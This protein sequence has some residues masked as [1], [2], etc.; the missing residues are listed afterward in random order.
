MPAGWLDRLGRR[1]RG[2]TPKPGA[3][4]AGRTDVTRPDE[5]GPAAGDPDVA[6]PY[7]GQ[8]DRR[9]PDAGHTDTVETHLGLEH[10]RLEG[11]RQEAGRQDGGR[12][13]D[14]RQEGG[15]REGAHQD[16]G[17]LGLGRVLWDG[18]V[19]GTGFVVRWVRAA[20]FEWLVGNRFALVGLVV[21]AL[22]ALYGVARLSTPPHAAAAHTLVPR[23]AAVVSSLAVCP[24]PELGSAAKTRFGLVSP[25]GAEG[26][27]NA[28]VRDTFG[29]R[30]AALNHA[31]GGWFGDV[32]HP[33]GPL[34]VTGSGAPAAGLTGGQI[35][36]G[37]GDKNEL[38][39][40]HCTRPA[41][42][43]WFVGPG[44]EDGDVRLRL[45]NPDNGPATVSV[46]VYSDAG[47]LDGSDASAIFVPPHGKADVSLAKRAA[48]AQLAALHVRTSM[49]RVAAAVQATGKS[50][51]GAD[52]VPAG[53]APA[54]KLVVPGV[55]KGSGDRELLVAAP[56]DHDATV[57]VAAATSDGTIVPGGEGV[58]QVPAGSVM[59]MPLDGMLSGRACALTLTS[60]VP[61]VAGLRAR[62]AISGGADVAYTAAEPPLDGRGVAA[63]NR[64]DH[65]YDA[66]VTLTALGGPVTVR[67]TPAGPAAPGRPKDVRVAAG[68]TTVVTPDA[69][70]G[71]SPAY[72]IVVTRRSG[73]GRLYAARTL[74]RKVDGGDLMTVDP[75]SPAPSTVPVLPATGTL[76]A[77]AP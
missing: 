28:S 60:D 20:P 59:P 41:T 67:V 27:G 58:L 47:H 29:K 1:A 26:R 18:G 54:K 3:P 37:K 56:G 16:G 49:G 7:A 8:A 50:H 45:A 63:A 34:I 30:V 21:V 17:R 11:G 75:L 70:T 52:W 14:V 39:G 19:R 12:Q 10:R 65:G 42:D 68:H 76:D 31:G 71:E 5:V 43:S 46:D 44:P 25:S 2:A 64:A 66:S 9:Q 69:P 24:G 72:G 51:E 38:T 6:A 57:K 13:G 61:V 33:S 62:S 4:E 32:T 36:A 15:W 23:R 55:P 77:V 74:T 40:T 53:S 35:S 48:G 73:A 22:A